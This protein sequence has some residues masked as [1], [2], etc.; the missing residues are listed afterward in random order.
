MTELH[1][2]VAPY[3]LDALDTEETRIFETHLESCPECQAE[4]VEMREG[5][6]VLASVA[7][8]RPPHEIKGKVMAAIDRPEA[9]N[10]VELAP[11][12]ARLAWTIATAAAAVAL[13]FF[14]LWTV[15]NNQ[16]SAA[17]QVAAVYEAPDAVVVE[18]ESTQGP[19]RFV[20]SERLGDG[21]LNGGQLVELDTNDV[22]ELWLIGSDG[23]V[24][25][26]TL[27]SGETAVLVD[28]ISPGLVLAMTVEPAPGVDA[29]TSDPIFATEL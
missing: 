8:V 21:V 14:G 10:V 6:D 28:G 17:E 12:R 4:L 27:V 24:P 2:L 25:A 23:A 29:P 1:D 18:L 9:S 16:L 7:S 19:V 15:A 22:Y 3:A 13:V 5:V 26:G 20:Y 11:R